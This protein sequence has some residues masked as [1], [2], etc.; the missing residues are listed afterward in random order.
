MSKGKKVSTEEIN[1]KL[2]EFGTHMIGEYQGSR[3]PIE[4][5]CSSSDCKN[6]R[7]M[8]FADIKRFNQILCEECRIKNSKKY[9]QEEAEKIFADQNCVLVDEYKNVKT[10]MKYICSCSSDEISEIT[11]EDFMRGK[12]SCPSCISD[13]L[14]LNGYKSVEV[15]KQ[16]AKQIG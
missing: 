2:K 15:R 8:Y 10:K 1:E 7:M 11:L 16:K 4:V 13:K 9:T 5:A 6:T 12:T 3:N 14:S